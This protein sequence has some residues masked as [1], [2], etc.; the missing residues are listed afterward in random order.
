MFNKLVV[1]L[2]AVLV[3]TAQ[4]GHVK[5]HHA[6]RHYGEGYGAVARNSTS[7]APQSTSSASPVPTS[8]GTVPVGP[9]SSTGPP[10]VISSTSTSASLLPT[11]SVPS[12]IGSS[13]SLLASSSI[14]LGTGSSAPPFPVISASP[15]ASQNPSSKVPLGTGVTGAPAKQ[16][17]LVTSDTVLTYT[18]GTGSSTTVVVTTVRHTRTST[19][20]QVS[21]LGESNEHHHQ[22]ALT[23]LIRPYM[24]P[25]HQLVSLRRQPLRSLKGIQ[26]RVL[27]P[28]HAYTGHL[29]LSLPST[30][31]PRKLPVLPRRIFKL[32][33][34]ISKLSLTT[35]RHKSPS[36]SPDQK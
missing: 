11:S 21:V 28:Q 5:H 15:S 35:V 9:G 26:S 14:P 12:S 25:S 24:R 18:I 31:S 4:A 20:V 19:V 16:V 29:P 32:D 2:T 13:A 6:R 17:S 10:L 22:V 8:S 33:K 30:L 7:V 36:L 3:V 34:T 1:A 23:E 27:R